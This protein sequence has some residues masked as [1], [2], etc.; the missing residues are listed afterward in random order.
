MLVVPAKAGT[1][2]L[3]LQWPEVAGSPPSRG[4]RLLFKHHLA[5][6]RASWPVKPE[7]RRILLRR[8]PQTI[9]DLPDNPAVV[10]RSR[11]G[12]NPVSLLSIAGSRWVPAFAGMTAVASLLLAAPMHPQAHQ[13]RRAADRDVRR[14]PPRQDGESEN[15]VSNDTVGLLRRGMAFLLVTFL[16]PDKEKLPAGP[17]G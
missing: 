10:R 17:K 7:R 15:P 2:C 5:T 9:N 11:E 12:G 13:T 14:F 6:P 8:F 16:W 4:R 3:C 1:Q